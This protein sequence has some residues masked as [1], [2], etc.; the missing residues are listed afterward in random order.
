MSKTYY[1][2]KLMFLK[3]VGKVNLKSKKVQG[4]FGDTFIL[5]LLSWAVFRLQNRVSYFF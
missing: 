3:L 1:G 5:A 2:E 4:L